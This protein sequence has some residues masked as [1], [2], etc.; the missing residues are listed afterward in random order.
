MSHPPYTLFLCPDSRLLRNRLDSL[1]TAHVGANPWQRHVFWGDEGLSPSFWEHLTLQGLFFTPKFLIVRNAQNIPVETLR[2][3][4]PFL[5]G[6]AGTDSSLV[7]PAICFEVAFEREKAKTP[8]HIQKLPFYLLA[9]KRGWIETI[10]PLTPQSFPA[11][12]REEAARAGLILSA[13]NIAALSRALPP[14]AAHA[15]SELA[16]LALTADASGRPTPD[17]LAEL[18]AAQEIGIFELIRL[19][20]Q[21][22]NTPAVWRKILEDRLGGENSIFA[23]ISLLL[24][25]GRILWQ[26]LSGNPPSLSPQ[27]MAGKKNIARSLGFAGLARIWELALIADKGIKTGE[28]SPE[29]AFEMLAADLF[30]LFASETVRR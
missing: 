23:F 9:E 6:L 29:Q 20:Q 4:S 30:L 5:E 21:R 19:L 10:P 27:T 8:N 14:D 28:R 25:E 26:I 12:L 1:A 7:W 16:K 2:M 24:R 11:F 22:A 3:L 18:G 13:A 15:S 17:A